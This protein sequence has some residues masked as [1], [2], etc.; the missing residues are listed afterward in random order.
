M[1]PGEFTV[2]FYLMKLLMPLSFFHVSSTHRHTTVKSNIW[3]N[4]IKK[5]LRDL[6]AQQ[7]AAA[8]TCLGS[9]SSP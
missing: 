4:N 9:G 7:V 2:F 1:K 6:E 5:R 8:A 3:G